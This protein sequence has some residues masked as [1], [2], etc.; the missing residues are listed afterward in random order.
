MTSSISR[1]QPTAKLATAVGR[2]PWFAGNGPLIRRDQIALHIWVDGKHLGF[3]GHH[4]QQRGQQLVHA[5]P[6][7]RRWAN[8]SG[9]RPW[10]LCH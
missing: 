7:R 6:P 2:A 10:L 4:Q 8:D 5:L 1:L 3:L 9:R